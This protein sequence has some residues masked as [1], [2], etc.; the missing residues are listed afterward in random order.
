MTD[1]HTP[2]LIERVE[3]A[4]GPDQELDADIALSIGYTRRMPK[5]LKHEY[6]F[7]PDGKCAD[8]E[9]FTGSLD[10]AMRLIPDKAMCDGGWRVEYHHDLKKRC[11][12][13]VWLHE[14]AEVGDGWFTAWGAT[15][16][17]A[18]TAASLKARAIP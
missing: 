15:P 8:P 18:I 9:P 6:W 14:H 7:R 12:A 3:R 17:L 4:T 5:G 1:G 2:D 11:H 13:T 16:A 10:A